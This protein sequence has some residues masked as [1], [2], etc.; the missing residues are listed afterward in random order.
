MGNLQCNGKRD[1]DHEQVSVILTEKSR[2]TNYTK[3]KIAYITVVGRRNNIFKLFS[4][5]DINCNKV[6][7][8]MAVLASFRGRN[9]H[10]L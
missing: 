4:I 5:E 2:K 6:A 7:F 1:S 9:L 10:N 3:K 8:G